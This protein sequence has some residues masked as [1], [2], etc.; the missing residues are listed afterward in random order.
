MDY[1]LKI[2]DATI[3]DGSGAPRFNGEIGVKDGRIV[4]VGTAT[5]DAREVIDAKG[6]VVSPGFID[7]HTHYDAQVFWDPSISPSVYHGVTT[8]LS[9]NCG[10]TLAPLSGRKEDT[11]YLLAM[12]AQVEGMPLKSLETAITP[13]WNSFG[14]YLDRIDDGLAVNM[15]F[16]VGHSALRRHVMG[17]RAIGHEATPEEIE[18]M[19]ALLRKSLSE[20]GAGFSTTKSY[21]HS[22][23]NGDPVPSRW[24]SNEEILALAAVVKE[25][26]GTWLEL[27]PPLHDPQ[28]SY[29]LSTAMSLAGGRAVN[30]NVFIV[31]AQQPE[32]LESQL[33]MGTYA[34][35]RGARVYG[36]IQA[37][38]M[39]NVIN[40]RTGIQLE[41]IEGWTP[42][43]HLPHDWKLAV[44]R[45]P[46]SRR[47]LEEA[48][49]ASFR[50]SGLPQDFGVFVIEFVGSERNARWVGKSVADYA[51]VVGKTAFD[52]LF[53]L[54]IEEDLQ[55]SFS[56]PAMGD[57]EAAWK[58]RG[59]IWQ[60]EHCLIGASD[61]GAHLDAI[62]TF[63][64]GTQL[65]GEGVRD[66]GILSLEEGVRRITSHL[67]DAFGLTGR[68]R[69]ASGAAADLVVFDPDTIA[70]G[71][72]GM[73][74]DLPGGE[75]RLYADAVGIHHVIVN[76]VPVAAGNTPTGRTGGRILRSGT[77]TYTVPLGSEHFQIE[78]A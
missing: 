18:A 16:L 4:A 27:L 12:L 48:K 6:A 57:D 38:A 30:W 63:A 72:I 25:F 26:P 29:E 2:V 65:L 59:E 55:L 35:E 15:A 36:L 44:M 61:A 13:T 37:V 53:D 54:A 34:A 9:G 8:V 78:S 64:V 67:A 41:L 68:G 11:D 66:R 47:K 62:N 69:I 20:G 50:R 3:V 45:D 52:A 33:R 49:D 74:N 21:S 23:H 10:F 22:D 31:N 73:R 7:C 40:F 58:L 24:A 70:C 60:N 14:E 5:G 1:D 32:R 56:G 77:D 76:G 19:A 71:S 43:I 75:T 39:K 17:S 46:V 42:F 51:A 28:S